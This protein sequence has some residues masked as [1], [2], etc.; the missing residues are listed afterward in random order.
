[1][2]PP[3]VTF[4]FN[5]L[6][7]VPCPADCL[8]P[9][10]QPDLARCVQ[11]PNTDECGRPGQPCCPRRGDTSDW[12]KRDLLPEL[13]CQV[14]NPCCGTLACLPKTTVQLETRPCWRRA[15]TGGEHVTC[16]RQAPLQ[17]MH[18]DSSAAL[19][20]GSVCEYNVTQ[21]ETPVCVANPPN[22]GALPRVALATCGLVWART[23]ASKLLS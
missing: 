16:M 23:T 4:L 21:G 18:A 10:G 13:P 9:A 6:P 20:I 17:R 8:T 15:A 3:S 11:L 22:C 14:G 7:T 12:D 2:L 19:Q 5:C 1:M